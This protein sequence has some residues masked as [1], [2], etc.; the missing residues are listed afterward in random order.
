MIQ[1]LLLPLILCAPQIDEAQPAAARP[2]TRLDLRVDPLV[3]LYQQVRAWAASREPEGIPP[4]VLASPDFKEAVEAARAVSAQLGRSPLAFGVLD[5]QLEGLESFEDLIGDFEALD[6]PVRVLGGAEVDIREEAVRFARALAAAEEAFLTDFWPEHEALI[7][8]ARSELEQTLVPKQAECL[9]FMLA[10]LGL[11]DPG[12]VVPVYLVR[13]AAA[14]GAYT[15]RRQDGGGLCFVS[16][17]PGG[18][19]LSETILHEATHAIDLLSRDGGVLNTLRARLLEAVPDR[20]DPIHRDLPHLL[21]FIQAGETVRRL[22]DPEHVH[23]GEARQLYSRQAHLSDV[24]LPVWKEHLDGRL[25]RE[26]ALDRL[27]ERTVTKP[28][29]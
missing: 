28:A 7:E 8:A 4:A 24:A 19:L 5:R 23:Y 26:E 29:H 16:V 12:D 25:T 21:M 27:L 10:S 6:G 3:D 11:E 13:S 2:P 15:Y 22:I 14:P 18:G 17:D 1:S 20:R 9:E